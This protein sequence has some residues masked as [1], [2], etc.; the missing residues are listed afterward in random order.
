MIW[1]W[2]RI[3][4]GGFGRNPKYERPKTLSYSYSRSSHGERARLA[5]RV[6]A[7]GWADAVAVT[8]KEPARGQ[9]DA[10]IL[11][12]G[13]TVI[14]MEEAYLNTR[15]VLHPPPA[16]PPIDTPEELRFGAERALFF[17]RLTGGSPSVR[18]SHLRRHV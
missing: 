3:H 7:D 16:S 14:A 13:K 11:A 2:G 17:D 5:R 18:A 12:I 1:V 9:E 8:L 6:L 15:S 10:V 4:D